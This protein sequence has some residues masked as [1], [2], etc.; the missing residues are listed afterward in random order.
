M[1]RHKRH[2]KNFGICRECQVRDGDSTPKRLIRCWFCKE[3]F[4][5]K[6]L[7]PKLAVMHDA[8]DKIENLSLRDKVYA[9]WRKSNGHPDITWTEKYFDEIKF[10]EEEKKQKI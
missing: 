6:H 5:K 1:R 8:I 4:C 7:H 9:E 10:N 2:S 3:L